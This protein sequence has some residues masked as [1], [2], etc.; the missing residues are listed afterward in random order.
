MQCFFYIRANSIHI[1][2]ETAEPT[3]STRALDLRVAKVYFDINIIIERK[4]IMPTTLAEIGI[5]ENGILPT[6]LTYSL[7][8]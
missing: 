6:V 1:T 8:G 7:N 4:Q 2:A 3:V 5:A